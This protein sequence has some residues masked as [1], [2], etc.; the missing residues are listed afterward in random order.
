MLTMESC[1]NAVFMLILMYSSGLEC[2]I[3][4]RKEERKGR[5]R[6]NELIHQKYDISPL[7]YTE[8]P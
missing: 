7:S 5:K 8:E 2:R 4:K 6:S 3:M 1:K